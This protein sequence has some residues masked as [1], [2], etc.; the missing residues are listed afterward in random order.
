MQPQEQSAILDPAYTGV[1]EASNTSVGPSIR[2]GPFLITLILT[3]VANDFILSIDPAP[4]ASAGSTVEPSGREYLSAPEGHISIHFII[5]SGVAASTFTHGR[6][7]TQNTCG[8][9]L[10]QVPGCAHCSGYQ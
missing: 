6:F 4:F 7:A 10:R 5:S 9:V 1:S 8:R 3:A 2:Y